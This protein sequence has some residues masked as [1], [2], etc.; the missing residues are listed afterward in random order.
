MIDGLKITMRGEELKQKI[1]ERI[2]HHNDE[3][4][5][6]KA[7]LARTPLEHTSD[8]P[9]LSASYCRS[10]MGRHSGRVTVLTLI[11]SYLLADE[12]YLLNETD[13]RSADLWPGVES[14]DTI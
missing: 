12:V 7:E 2:A 9:F 4:R 14:S 13:L 10:E 1:G 8:R 11:S 3:V 5:R 6:F